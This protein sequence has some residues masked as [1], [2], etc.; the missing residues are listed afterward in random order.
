MDARCV[1]KFWCW[2]W[3]ISMLWLEGVT[4]HIHRPRWN[5][6]SSIITLKWDSMLSEIRFKRMSAVAGLRIEDIRTLAE[7]SLACLLLVAV[8]RLRIGHWHTI[9][10]RVWLISIV[11]LL[12][13]CPTT[14]HCLKL[15]D[16]ENTASIYWPDVLAVTL[17]VLLELLVNIQEKLL[18]LRACH[19]VLLIKAWADAEM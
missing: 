11:W 15:F 18:N 12:D 1:C 9:C 5:L 8:V 2:I 14:S 6:L 3:T 16:L 17:T 10:G 4:L 19:H 13:L 7:V